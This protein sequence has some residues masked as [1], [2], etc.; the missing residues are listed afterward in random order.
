MLCEGS[1]SRGHPPPVPVV[2][3]DLVI[4][5]CLQQSLLPG[6]LPMQLGSLQPGLVQSPDNLFLVGT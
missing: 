2:A 1:A 3:P 4:L 5:A 6:T